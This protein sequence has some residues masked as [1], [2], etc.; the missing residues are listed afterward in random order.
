MLWSSCIDDSTSENSMLNPDGKSYSF[1][2]RGSGYGRG[3]GA[4]MVVLKR[5]TDALDSGDPIRAII[6]NTGVNQDGKTNGITL[7]NQESQKDLIQ[8]VY[9]CAGLRPQ[10][11]GYIEAHGTG[12][13]VGDARELGAIA[14]VFGRNG[15]RQGNDSTA[16]IAVGSIKANIGHTESA[17]GV[18]ALIK[19][20]LVLEK[21]SIPPN[22]NLER[23]KDG[24]DL[25]N[26][27]IRVSVG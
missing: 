14:D 5:L 27:N 2:H 1:D 26:S 18:A 19:A 11:T 13:V 17:A 7:P 3:E 23:L 9:A 16:P 6:R 20:V 4:G 22:M 8:A 15:E 24:L 21:G 10:E 25:E 12:T